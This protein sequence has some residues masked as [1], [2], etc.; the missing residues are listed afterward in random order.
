[1]HGCLRA[2]VRVLRGVFAG[3]PASGSVL[4][5]A[6]RPMSESRSRMPTASARLIPQPQGRLHTASNNYMWERTQLP[7]LHIVVIVLT[8]GSMVLGRGRGS[9]VSDASRDCSGNAEDSGQGSGSGADAGRALVLRRRRL[10][11]GECVCGCAFGHGRTSTGEWARV[12]QRDPIAGCPAGS[13]NE[14]GP[15]HRPR[16]RPPGAA[17]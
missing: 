6:V 15:F 5:S 14:R 12:L 9:G 7:P 8:F 11:R 16:S 3:L 17:G 4:P 13:G 10:A 1:M 2:D